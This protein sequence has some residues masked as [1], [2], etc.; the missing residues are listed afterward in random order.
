MIQW[1]V[2]SKYQKWETVPDTQLPPGFYGNVL[3]TCS[4]HSDNFITGCMARVFR[5]CMG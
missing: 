3:K 5:T 1:A 2:F 4:P